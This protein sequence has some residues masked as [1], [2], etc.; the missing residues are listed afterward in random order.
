MKFGGP[1]SIIVYY[2]VQFNLKCCKSSVPDMGHNTIFKIKKYISNDILKV[3]LK[4]FPIYN[5]YEIW[6]TTC[7]IKQ[8]SN[9]Q[10]PIK[11]SRQS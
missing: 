4:I 8:Y 3:K 10:S 1:F 6:W 7:E 9:I 11:F 2:R 5:H